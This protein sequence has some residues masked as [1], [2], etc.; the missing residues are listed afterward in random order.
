MPRYGKAGVVKALLPHK[1]K[2]SPLSRGGYDRYQKAH[3]ELPTWPTVEAAEEQLAAAGFTFAEK[4]KV[5]A[6]P[7]V[8][9]ALLPHLSEL[10]PLGKRKYKELRKRYADLPFWESVEPHR[11]AL[12]AA[13][14]AFA[15]GNKSWTAEEVIAALTPHKE[16][17]GPLRKRGVEDYCK[18]HRGLPSWKTV[19][20]LRSELSAAGFTFKKEAGGTG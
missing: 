4:R 5:W 2:V 1:E 9:A 7:E 11:D 19:E 13:G 6:E 16:A 17:L 8:V 20:R 10:K 15:A 18:D 3:R 14:F 12:A